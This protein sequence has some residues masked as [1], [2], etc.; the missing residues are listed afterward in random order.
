M[1]HLRRNLHFPLF[2]HVSTS[3]KDGWAK[4][5]WH[6][7]NCD[8]MAVALLADSHYCDKVSCVP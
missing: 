6:A 8:S 5:A 7:M 4:W 2:P 1:G 3:G